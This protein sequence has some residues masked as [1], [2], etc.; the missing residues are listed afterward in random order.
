M[1]LVLLPLIFCLV[2]LAAG[3]GAGWV[4]RPDPKDSRPET[5]AGDA[6][7]D[8]KVEAASDAA[9]EEGEPGSDISEFVRLNNQFIVPVVSDAQV[10]SLVLLSLSLEVETGLR[11]R[12]YEREPKLRDTLLQVMFD[13]ANIGGF[14][15]AFT[16]ADTLDILRASL[17]DAARN[18]VDGEV[19][20]V[21]IVDIARQDV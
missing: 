20:G 19:F 7:S 12:V 1:R 9:P 13:H 14:D 17:T 2:G 18:V 10:K 11:E 5:Q 4:L 21:L 15:G 6:N 3:A 8:G 16:Q